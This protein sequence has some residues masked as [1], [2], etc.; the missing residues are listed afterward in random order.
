MSLVQSHVLA[1]ANTSQTQT[2][3]NMTLGDHVAG[4]LEAGD[5]KVYPMLGARQ[6]RARPVMDSTPMIRVN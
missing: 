4:A 1:A 3:Q 6:I 5:V 2:S